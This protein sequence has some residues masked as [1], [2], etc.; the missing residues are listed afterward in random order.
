M[1][2]WITIAKEAVSID[3]YK[4]FAPIETLERDKAIKKL[5]G[6]TIIRRFT[7]PFDS[8]VEIVII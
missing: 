1:N 8:S 7:N 6:K 2:K 4:T 3:G 5:D